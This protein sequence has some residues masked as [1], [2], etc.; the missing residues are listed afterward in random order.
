MAVYLFTDAD[1]CLH[2]TCAAVR[3]SYTRR[4]RSSGE[5]F[6]GRLRSLNGSRR[7]VRGRPASSGMEPLS[8]RCHADGM[9]TNGFRRFAI[10]SEV[11]VV[12]QKRCRVYLT[13]TFSPGR[14]RQASFPSGGACVL[15]RA[16]GRKSYASMPEVVLG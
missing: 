1:F 11:G 6:D 4:L 13:D 14:F 15:R 5:A 2:D 7:Q 10:V 12:E 8:R 3:W 9:R 16:C